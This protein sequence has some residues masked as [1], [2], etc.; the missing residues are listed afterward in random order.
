MSILVG[1]GASSEQNATSQEP[2]MHIARLICAYLLAIPLIIFGANYFLHIFPLPPGDG[3][4]GA[5]LLQA[6]RDGHLMGFVAFSHV[7]A[8]VL[9]A[10]PQ[11]RF[12]GAMLQ[13]PMTIGIVSFHLAMQ[14][15]GLVMAIPMLIL[16]VVAAF[17]PDRLR[18]LL[19]LA[20]T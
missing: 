12:L 11:T 14:Q 7:V 4:P 10:V 15:S 19:V 9:L 8:G 13:L 5:A 17:E 3:S 2:T 20:K 16:N 6:M 18:A 1:P